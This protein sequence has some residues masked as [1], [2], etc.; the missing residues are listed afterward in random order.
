LASVVAIDQISKAWIVSDLAKG[1]I[2]ASSGNGTIF[3][4][5]K[6]LKL[7]PVRN[8]GTAFRLFLPLLD[9]TLAYGF[10]LALSAWLLIRFARARPGPSVRWAVVLVLG[11]A[12]GN[13][14]DRIR[15]GWVVDFLSVGFP[16]IDGRLP[17]FNL[18]DIAICIGA[19]WLAWSEWR[20]IQGPRDRS[21]NRVPAAGTDGARTK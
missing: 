19:G 9:P 14:I 18:A 12:S 8:T 4:L 17:T 20:G 13:F 1:A 7:V 11:G 5:G 10:L 2:S 16:G 15:S 6:V 21:C 3:V